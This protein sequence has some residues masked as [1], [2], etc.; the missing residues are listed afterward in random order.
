MVSN[1]CDE[2]LICEEKLEE[3]TKRFD[4][5]TIEVFFSSFYNIGYVNTERKLYYLNVIEIHTEKKVF[6]C[7]FAIG[8]TRPTTKKK[9]FS[10][11]NLRQVF[12]YPLSF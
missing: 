2:L 12:S 8:E 3:I 5:V 4:L 6:N 7:W 9:I 1:Q 11:N 10:P